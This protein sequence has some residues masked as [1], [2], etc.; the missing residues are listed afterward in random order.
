MVMLDHD[1]FSKQFSERYG[2]MNIRTSVSIKSSLRAAAFKRIALH[3]ARGLACQVRDEIMT[4]RRLHLDAFAPVCMRHL[5]GRIRTYKDIE[6]TR[7]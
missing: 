3:D 7:K 4:L 6:K 1:A 5:Y 2:V